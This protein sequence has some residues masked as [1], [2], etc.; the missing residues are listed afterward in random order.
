MAL[1]QPQAKSQ[2]RFK[3]EHIVLGIVILLLIIGALFDKP[4]SQT[5]MD[6]NSYFGTLFQNYSLVFPA[7]IIFMSTQVFFYR[8]QQSNVDA[9]GKFAVMFLTLVVAIYETWQTVKIALI[10]TISSLNNIK[11]KAPIGAANNDNGKHAALPTWYMP[12]LVIIT[13]IL[14]IA[15]LA[16]CY[17]WLATKDEAEMQRLTYVALAAALTVLAADTIVNTMKD[18]WGRFRPYEMKSDWSNFTSWLH[19]NGQN[20]HKSFPSGHSQEA[21]I[22]LLLP[23]FVSPKLG[24]KRRNTFIFA[25]VFGCL[26]ALS[27]LRLGAHFLSDVTMGSFISILVI[28]V[29]ARILNEKL[30]GDP[31]NNIN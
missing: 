10:Y 19:V 31:L 11:N 17:K 2:A 27:R 15:G 20:G 12:T 29:M 24:Q 6:Q 21:W 18:F 7:I 22:A 25:V 1:T 14:V 30:M 13:I 28:Y 3:I 26:V 4:I 23:L 8:I 16:L 5:I 9:I